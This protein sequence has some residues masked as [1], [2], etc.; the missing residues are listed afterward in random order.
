MLLPSLSHKHRSGDHGAVV[1]SENRALEFALLLTIPAAIAL[2]LAA[3]PIVRV[4]FQ[5]G[6]FTAIDTNA[7]AA[8]LAAFAL[9][10]PAYVL[11]KVL[12][13]SFFAREDTKTPMI[14]AG[15][16]MAANVVLS[17]MLF[18]S[19]GATGIAI[20]TTLAGWINVALLLSK[21]RQRQ[22]FRFD[23][24]LPPP[25]PR[26]PRRKRTDGRGRLCAAS[27]ADP[28]VRPRQR[29]TGTSRGHERPGRRRPPDLSRRGAPVR[30]HQAR[31][32]DQGPGHLGIWR[33]GFLRLCC[34]A[35]N[36]KGNV[37]QGRP[38]RSVLYM[39]GSNARALEKAKTLH[40]DALILD[41]EDA[42]APDAKARRPRAGLAA[43]KN[44]GYGG[45]EI[46]IRVNALETPWGID[47]LQPP[48][49][50]SPTPSSC[51]RS[52][53]PATSSAPPSILQGVHAAE[54]LRL[55]AMMETPMAILNAR[56]IAATAVYAENRL[57]VRHG[58]Q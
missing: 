17:I 10:L 36:A 18:T 22:G 51:R 15:I 1:A 30:C 53:I 7:T 3:E 40:A 19:I 28:L 6:A 24:R 9:G 8:M 2:Y 33:T 5:R 25:L 39:P 32:S 47:D 27:R 14:Y 55:W 35:A 34:T 46:V 16:A 12:Q 45:R 37:M 21:L 13:P 50:P 54:K 31:R 43:V 58:H 20:A 48:A 38:R 57:G 49:R 42:V 56:T 52:C 11:V 4:L 41:L 29:S 44:G 26:Y 23:T